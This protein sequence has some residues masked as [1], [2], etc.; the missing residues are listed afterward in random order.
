[1]TVRGALIAGAI[2]G[3]IAAISAAP[4]YAQKEQFIAG[5]RDL[6]SAAAS[7]DAPRIQAAADRMATGLAQWD[8]TISAIETTKI[9]ICD[10]EI[11]AFPKRR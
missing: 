6:S 7:N 3:T 11:A 2:V 5:V 9:R 1:M 8:R 4:A 10:F